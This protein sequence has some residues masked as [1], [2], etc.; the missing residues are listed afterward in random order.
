[1]ENQTNRVIVLLDQFTKDSANTITYDTISQHATVVQDIREATPELGDTVVFFEPAAMYVATPA[2]VKE[3]KDFAFVLVYSNQEIADTFP[4][5]V[6]KVKCGC[7]VIDWNLVYAVL[8]QDM[9]IL[10]TYANRE[11]LDAY[12]SFE[13]KLPPDLKAYANRLRASYISNNQSMNDLLRQNSKL[14]EQLAVQTSIGERAMSGLLEMKELFDR[15][16]TKLHSYELMLSASSNVPFNDFYADKPNILLVKSISHLAG[17]DVLLSTLYSVITNQ[18]RS[19]CKVVKLVDSSNARD[20]RYTPNNYKPLGDAF[21]TSEIL[22]NDFILKLGAYNGL[23]D[24][25]LLNRSGL[26]YLIVHDMRGMLQPCLDDSLVTLRLNEMTSDYAAIGE[27]SNILSEEGSNVEFPWSDA[28]CRKYAG[29]KITRLT[30]HPTVT[31]ILSL[32]I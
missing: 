31:K 4:S 29:T 21:D 20:I 10:D 32:I 9:A 24:H 2:I 3:L 25:L 16:Q 11:P 22:M 30:N 23:F 19:S 26:N 13:Q 28:E 17:I 7:E 6:K 18:Y 1:M 8:Y 5:N 12:S 27:Y 14:Q 15:A